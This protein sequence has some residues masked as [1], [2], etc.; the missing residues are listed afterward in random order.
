M[1]HEESGRT[2]A[3]CY[4]RRSLSRRSGHRV[5]PPLFF[6]MVQFCGGVSPFVSGVS[7]EIA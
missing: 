3:D 6:R 4:R 7:S 2:L 5:L 1:P